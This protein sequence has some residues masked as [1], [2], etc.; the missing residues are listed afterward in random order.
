MGIFGWSYPPGCS[1]PPEQDSALSLTRHCK[2]RGD[3][4]EVFWDEEGNLLEIYPSHYKDPDG[5][6]YTEGDSRTVGNYPW[7]D[8]LTDEENILLAA[9]HYNTLDR[10]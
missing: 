7:R 3:T 4:T 8:E 6:A 1:G 5:Y 2:L 10:K 9:N